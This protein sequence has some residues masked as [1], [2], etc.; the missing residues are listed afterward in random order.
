MTAYQ[1][2]VATDQD[3]KTG[4]LLVNLGTPNRPDADAVRSHINR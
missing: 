3:D 4:V 1:L 2:G